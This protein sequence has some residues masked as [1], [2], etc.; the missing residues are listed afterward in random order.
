M[1]KRNYYIS[2]IKGCA[3]IG[4]LLIHLIDWSNIILTPTDKLWRELAYPAV[5]FFVSTVGSVVYV[6][7][8]HR[9]DFQKTV[10]RLVSRGLQ[11]IGIYYLY[12][13]IKL[14]IYDF[15]TSPFYW[16]FSEKHIFD[17]KNILTLH[18]FSVPITIIYTIGL[19]LVISP[20]F[21]WIT[22]KFKHSKLIIFLLIIL[23]SFLNYCLPPGGN[24]IANFVYSRDIVI[25]PLALWLL[26]YLIGF[27]LA[28]IG[29]DRHKGKLLALFI[30]L[31]ALT[32]YPLHASG[33]TWQLSSYMYPI[34]LYYIFASFTLMYALIWVFAFVEKTTKGSFAVLRMTATGFLT[35]MRFLGDRTLSLYLFHWIVIDLTIW[36]YFPRVK[37][38]WVW[39]PI[40]VVAYL[41]FH[42]KKIR[43]YYNESLVA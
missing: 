17:W 23:L 8:A 15:D 31:T 33:A 22:K 37:M 27:Y 21:L 32:Y 6:A 35:L 29:F 9:D 38:I 16:Q 5:L 26:P 7:Y 25:F 34:K 19:L 10:W 24:F 36:Y 28:M 39:G 43:K 13:L 11:L 20:I 1:T 4:V 18:S 41:C 14:W 42:Y 40:F 3:I 30:F 12:N 2:Y